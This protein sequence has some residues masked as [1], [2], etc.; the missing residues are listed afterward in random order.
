V[1]A[2]RVARSRALFVLVALA[3]SFA[4]LALPGAGSAAP[5]LAGDARPATVRVADD[6][7]VLPVATAVHDRSPLDRAPVH[8]LVLV[9]VLV[10][11]CARAGA[12]S[13]WRATSAG[14]ADRTPS[15]RP[16][17]SGRAPPF[18]PLLTV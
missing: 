4:F 3:L 16:R 6:A 15:P 7:A 18:A 11:L 2:P 5:A 8:R 10:A 1:I 12:G 13:S 17:R 9:A 14:A